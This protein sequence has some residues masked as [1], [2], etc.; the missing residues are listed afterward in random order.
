[1][2]GAVELE[3]Q[4]DEYHK[5]HMDF[6]F[7]RND[8]ADEFYMELKYASYYTSTNKEKQRIFNDLMRLAFYSGEEDKYCYFIMCGSYDDFIHKF[9][10]EPDDENKVNARKKSNKDINNKCTK[11]YNRIY[12]KWFSFDLE[13]P[14]K[15]ISRKSKISKD[16]IDCYNSNY[17]KMRVTHIATELISIIPYNIKEKGDEVMNPSAVAIWRVK[18]V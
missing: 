6:H 10:F 14:G 3:M 11:Q 12:S 17:D 2:G 16:Y 8:N 13:K 4:L 7:K 15:D 18:K 9:V 5:R 1:M